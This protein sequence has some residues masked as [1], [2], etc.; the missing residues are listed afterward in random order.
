[1]GENFSLHAETWLCFWACAERSKLEASDIVDPEVPE[2]L[3]L[4]SDF[5]LESGGHL[6]YQTL[7]RFGH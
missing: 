7:Q 1:M 2:P 5:A 4:T 6:G 3:T